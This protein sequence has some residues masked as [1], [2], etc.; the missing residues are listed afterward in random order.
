MNIKKVIRYISL[1]PY[2]VKEYGYRTTINK[3]LVDISLKLGFKIPQKIRW[4]AAHQ[5]HTAWKLQQKKYYGIEEY[6]RRIDEKSLE[7]LNEFYETGTDF[8]DKVVLDVGCGTRGILPVINAKTKIGADPTIEKVRKH[9]T[10]N[11]SIIYLSE[12]AEEL[13]LTSESVDIIVCNNTLNHVENPELALAQ[14][15]RILKPGGFLLIE[16]FIEPMNI[17]HTV[18]FSPCQLANMLGKYFTPI[19]VKHERLRVK[20]EI[21]EKLDGHLPMRWGGIFQK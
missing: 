19:K 3:V 18:T 10:L 2:R 17:A 16:V 13:T 20:V 7:V 12:K 11:N 9:F 1:I 5:F 15:H 14:M 21:D 6:N 8:T 4:Q